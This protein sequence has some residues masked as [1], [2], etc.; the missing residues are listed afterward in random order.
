MNQPNANPTELIEDPREAQEQAAVPPAPAQVTPIDLGPIIRAVHAVMSEVRVIPKSGK[1]QLGYS[2]STES[3]VL[4]AVRP[5]MLR[6]GLVLLPSMVEGSARTESYQTRN[7]TGIRAFVTTRYFLSHIS[8]TVWPEALYQAGMAEDSSD[9]AIT[10]A[11]TSAHK[12]FMLRFFQVETGEDSDHDGRSRQQARTPSSHG[13]TA[14]STQSPPQGRPPAAQAPNAP[15]PDPPPPPQG[16]SQGPR[17]PKGYCGNCKENTV[18]ASNY[19]EPGSK[20]CPKCKA[21]YPAAVPQGPYRPTAM[22]QSLMNDLTALVKNSGSP[23]LEVLEDFKR[24]NQPALA[25]FTSDDG[26][27]FEDEAKLMCETDDIPF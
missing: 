14:A 6:H 17:E 11:I 12:Y 18:I 3:D 19:G 16:A 5:A 15:R 4:S 22:A 2:Y 26:L 7:G 25:E 1:H 13:N 10:K 8:G 27:W 24:D 9:K 23:A 21:K 20:W